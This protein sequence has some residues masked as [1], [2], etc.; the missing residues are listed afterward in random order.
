[1][2]LLTVGRDR[3][4]NEPSDFLALVVD[5][6]GVPARGQFAGAREARRPGADHGD[7]AAVRSLT[8]P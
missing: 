7:A 5:R 6:D 4:A 3:V 1:M 8:V 2:T